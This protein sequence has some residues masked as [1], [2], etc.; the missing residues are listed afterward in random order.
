ME[1]THQYKVNLQWNSDR[2]G[3]LSSPV[4]PSQIEVATPPDFPKEMSWNIVPRTSF[5]A[6]VNSCVMTTFLAIAENSKV[7]FISLE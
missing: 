5:D 4:L 7:E 3:A 2:K 6:A 1:D